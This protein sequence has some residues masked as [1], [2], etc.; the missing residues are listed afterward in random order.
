MKEKIVLKNVSGNQK[1]THELRSLFLYT[2]KL[3]S[4]VNYG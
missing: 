2:V 4:S 1:K 3:V